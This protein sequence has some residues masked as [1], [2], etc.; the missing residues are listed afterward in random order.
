MPRRKAIV[1]GGV[2]TYLTQNKT[3]VTNGD[4]KIEP[5]DG[6]LLRSVNIITSGPVG[7]NFELVNVITKANNY[8]GSDILI[9]LQFRGDIYANMDQKVSLYRYKKGGTSSV[10]I[11]GDER[12]KNVYKYVKLNDV[13]KTDERVKMYCWKTS[14]DIFY[15]STD[16]QKTDCYL[17]RDPRDLSRPYEGVGNRAYIINELIESDDIEITCDHFDEGDISTYVNCGSPNLDV[18][19]K[20]GVIDILL[21]YTCNYRVLQEPNQVGKIKRHI[22]GSYMQ[23]TPIFPCRLA[24]ML[25]YNKGTFNK[26]L[27]D[28]TSDEFKKL[29][30]PFLIYPWTTLQLANRFIGDKGKLLTTATQ[31]EVDNYFKSRNSGYF[32]DLFSGRQIGNSSQS[33]HTFHLQFSVGDYCRPI[34][35]KLVIDPSPNGIQILQ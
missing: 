19:D 3:V 28:Y 32:V 10:V 21:G 11:D 24:D 15:Y 9:L 8:E 26:T 22:Y 23:T 4:I 29:E 31:S 5:N 17:H 18:L 7:D 35:K 2:N 33:L 16:L 25:V 14:D 13:R 12:K 30:K 1:G 34:S 6:Y 27:S 20:K